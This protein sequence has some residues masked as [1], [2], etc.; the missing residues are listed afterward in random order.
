MRLM[1]WQAIIARF[2]RGEKTRALLLQSRSGLIGKF[3]SGL[4][5]DLN[6]LQTKALR[7]YLTRLPIYLQYPYHPKMAHFSIVYFI[8]IRRDG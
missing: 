4:L 8:E 1:F 7:E 5:N 3:F 6:Q 2:R